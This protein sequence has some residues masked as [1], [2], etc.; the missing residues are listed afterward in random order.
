MKK[1]LMMG[2]MM[3]VS[4]CAVQAAAPDP[5]DWNSQA[6]QELKAAADKMFKDLDKGDSGAILSWKDLNPSVFDVDPENKAVQFY[7]EAEVSKYLGSMT[8]A[9]KAGLK[10]K[11]VVK[12]SDCQ[13][14]ASMG[15]CTIEFDQ[16]ATMGD[17]T[18]G[19]SKFRGTMIARKLPSGWK[20][21]HWHGSFREMPA[22]AAMPA[23][24]A[25]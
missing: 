13:A 17:Q 19:P 15:F 25:H 1:L 18:M 16:T 7:G 14:T 2:L 24:H 11:S 9:V 4:G 22:M 10:I 3:A 21:T 5:S 6:T 12:R 20:W 23:E 8:E